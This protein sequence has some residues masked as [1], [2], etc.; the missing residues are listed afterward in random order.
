MKRSEI[1]AN[2]QKWVDRLLDPAST[3]ATGILS[4]TPTQCCCLGHGCYAL[5]IPRIENKGLT[6]FCFGNELA[7]CVAPSELIELVGLYTS[8]GTITD[9][10]AK[11]KNW[12]F[13][14]LSGL[15]DATDVTTQQIGEYLQSVIEGGTHTPFKPLSEYEE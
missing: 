5:E 3:K 7:N 13:N 1:L 12:R 11:I 14:S 8:V 9:G 15:N 6:L 10:P 4:K 2:R